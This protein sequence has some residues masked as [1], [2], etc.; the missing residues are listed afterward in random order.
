[1]MPVDK[2]RHVSKPRQQFALTAPPLPLGASIGGASHNTLAL[3]HSRMKRPHPP[4]PTFTNRFTRTHTRMHTHVR[5]H[6]HARAC[7]STVGS[8]NAVR[9]R[10]SR[11][12]CWGS[13]SCS[14]G[15]QS[16]RFARPPT[17]T[18]TATSRPSM[19]TTAPCSQRSPRRC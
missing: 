12:E 16:W 8:N 6:T 1:M 19:P 9:A 13:R 3:R 7:N 5:T 17:R 2:S 15:W 10:T 14:A 4:T 18:A 11:H